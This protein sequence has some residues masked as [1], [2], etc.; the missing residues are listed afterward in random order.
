MDFN[1]KEGQFHIIAMIVK[2][3]SIAVL[4]LFILIIT[5]LWMKSEFKI[6]LDLNVLQL[7]FH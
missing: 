5:F 7:G 4:I 3:I 2:C 6:A 1:W